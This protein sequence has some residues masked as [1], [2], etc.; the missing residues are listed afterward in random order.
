MFSVYTNVYAKRISFD[1]PLGK[2]VD[3]THTKGSSVV[4]VVVEITSFL[5]EE[6]TNLD[7]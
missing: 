6:I 4:D 2:V 3:Y 5:F 1:P 7:V